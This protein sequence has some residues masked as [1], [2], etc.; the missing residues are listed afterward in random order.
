M[1]RL[2]RIVLGILFLAGILLAQ[3]I[4]AQTRPLRVG[5][6]Q[7][8]PMISYDDEGNTS[9][10]FI[11]LL[12]DFGE[13]NGYTFEYVQYSFADALEALENGEIDILPA[14][15]HST[16]RE[17]LFD[18]GVVTVTTSWGELYVHE[19]ETRTI[20][21]ITDLRGLRVAALR[22]DY[23]LNNPGNGLK[24]LLNEIGVETEIVEYE[25]YADVLQAINDRTA[26]AALVSKTYGIFNAENYDIEKTHIPLAYVSLRYAFARDKPELISVMSELDNSLREMIR[27]NN[28]VYYTLHKKYF[29][30]TSSDFIPDWF[31]KILLFLGVG[32]TVLASVN[33]LLQAQV[34]KKTA[35]LARANE[36]LI[37]SEREARLADVTI[38]TSKDI[39]FWFKPGK[40]FIR[41]NQAAIDLL[42]YTKQELLAMR[43]LSLL[44]SKDDSYFLSELR[45]EGWDGHL[46]MESTFITKD[47][48][49]LPVELSLDRI[50]F[51]GVQYV[52]G[53]A[54]D[55][56]LRKAS[57]EALAQSQ[58]RL[59]LALQAANEG[60]WDIDFQT[61]LLSFD[62]KFVEALGYS[63][64]ELAPV[65]ETWNNLMHPDDLT[66]I[67]EQ[68]EQFIS[69][70]E[71]FFSLE[72]RLKN[73][74]DEYL[75]FLFHGKV[76]RFDK[77]HRP[78]AA[79]G[80]IVNINDLKTTMDQN[81][82]LLFSLRER[83][84]ELR[85]LYNIS[86]LV[87]DSTR[88]IRDVMAEAVTIVPN[89]LRYAEMAGVKIIFQD[90]EFM[91]DGF[92][93]SD[94]KMTADI[95]TANGPEGKIIITY[96][97]DPD[98][99]GE[100]AFLEEEKDM[101]EALSQQLGNMIDAKNAEYRVVSSILDTEDK[102]R[103]RISKEIHDSIGQTLSA[104]SLNMDMVCKDKD[105]LGPKARQKL[106]KSIELVHLAVA[107]SR[108][109]SH[110]LMPAT[111]SDFG[112]V[113]SVE[114]LIDSVSDVGGT[115]FKF[116][117]NLEDERLPENVELGLFR[118]TQE[119]LNNVIKHAKATE[120]VIQLLKH[121]D[122]ALL[123][124][125]DDGRGFNSNDLD[126][127]SIFGLNSM[128]NRALAIH[129]SFTLDS[130]PGR[131]TIITVEVPL[132]NSNDENTPGR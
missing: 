80:T 98:I 67:D 62:D 91:N 65:R 36:D 102:E 11:D 92:V 56:S 83:N 105:E 19:G 2:T 99:D 123:T 89:A 69:S 74:E 30:P 82:N 86:Q 84:K 47:G 8:A 94:I 13:V 51:E 41:V 73:N 39:G 29:V 54:R 14:V 37:N 114:N 96:A 71:D 42:G 88:N 107:E 122:M 116:Y 7:S 108:S 45:E 50:N 129:A 121:D 126:E 124:I 25:T 63:P 120:V 132:N 1:V 109:I 104:I 101:I 46:R 53:F 34:K 16:E 111:L 38:E 77:S 127:I 31:W 21:D 72:F 49:L 55:I 28:S 6:Y 40:T 5:V 110:N 113:I 103:K 48:E 118:I 12:L 75:W 26:Q 24:Q 119:A 68:F 15:G 78:L 112:Y 32:I 85:C 100:G 66:R 87:A 43:P 97:Q 117:S 58:E 128:K 33:V 27:N 18:F 93:D 59:Q 76:T 115:Q 44:A 20:D 17:K 4:L 95:K 79:M 9:G 57:Q 35:E 23:Y 64:I 3:T 90:K 52:C 22:S 10:F 70:K 130:T 125:E 131:G 60:M 106:E 81:Q 61:G